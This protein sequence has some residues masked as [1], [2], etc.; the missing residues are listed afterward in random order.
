MSTIHPFQR[1]QRRQRGL[2]A[3]NLAAA[4]AALSPV[5]PNL[6]PA[7]LEAACLAAIAPPPPPA[8]AAARL[9]SATVAADRLGVSI[10][11]VR[12]LAARGVLKRV[13]LGW[14]CDRFTEASVLALIA[15]AG[16]DDQTVTTPAV[17]GQTT[18][19]TE[20]EVAK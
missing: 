10:K 3:A 1:S 16:T 13:K 7:A 18:I 9:V 8:P 20:N 5:L 14:K 12:R 2:P 4:C 19:A 6:T 17:A 11:T 15:T